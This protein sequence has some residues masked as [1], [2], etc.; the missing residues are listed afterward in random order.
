MGEAGGGTQVSAV[1]VSKRAREH[2]Q[3][4]GGPAAGAP[5]ATHSV[6]ILLRIVFGSWFDLV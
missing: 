5:A 2:S 1:S 3:G 6:L 4:Q